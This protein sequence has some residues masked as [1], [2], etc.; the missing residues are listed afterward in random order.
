MLDGADSVGLARGK[1]AKNIRLSILTSIF[2]KVFGVGIQFLALPFAERTLGGGF[3]VFAVLA[4]L[5]SV[6]GLANLG[7]GPGITMKLTKYASH[8]DEQEES[9]WFASAL[10]V[11]LVSTTI[12]ISIAAVVGLIYPMQALFGETI[13]P[14]SAQM[15]F[16]YYMFI[17]LVAFQNFLST[18]TFA[19]EGYLEAYKPRLVAMI[20][21]GLSIP[22]S[23][24]IC[25]WNPNAIGVIF[26]L[27]G[28][29]ILM[30]S[31]NMYRLLKKDRTYLKPSF[32][33]VDKQKA[34]NLFSSNLLFTLTSSGN[35]LTRQ[36]V[37]LIVAKF[38][39]VGSPA[40]GAMMLTWFLLTET[41]YAMLA[42][43]T[44]PSFSNAVK[45]NDWPWIKHGIIKLG[46]ALLFIA[47]CAGLTVAFAGV[48]VAEFLYTGKQ[49]VITQPLAAY[50]GFV[51]FLG[52]FEVGIS[53]LLYAYDQL[54][55][56]ATLG[57]LQAIIVI[58]VGIPLIKANG[59]VGMLQ[60]MTASLGAMILMG[61][62]VLG[63]AILA[64]RA[65]FKSELLVS[66]I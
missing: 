60:A 30:Q 59:L 3:Q 56:S 52:A 61:G 42:G 6:L 47:T 53:Q 16:G 14:Y 45:T 18:F 28:I 5:G 21:Y 23:L 50:L 44:W 64:G 34:K 62:F 65:E 13:A 22:V 49:V 2:S 25:Y 41:L 29:P 7:H 38:G 48:P 17:V 40:T 66:K 54:K 11:S 20:A 32:S 37:V 24:A 19:Y 31:V 26:A 10:F 35:I 63:K 57:V 8:P 4:V 39:P 12:I 36:G 33:I 51:I 46:S 9:T 27:H 1:R 58:S 43:S 15:R 55:T